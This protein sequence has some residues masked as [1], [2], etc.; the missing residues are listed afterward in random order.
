MAQTDDG[1]KRV[2]VNGYRTDDGRRVPDHYRTPPCPVPKK[3]GK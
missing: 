1:K 3:T 2:F